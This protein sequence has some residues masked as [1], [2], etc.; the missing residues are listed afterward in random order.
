MKDHDFCP[1]YWTRERLADQNPDHVS[2]I[3]P[4]P[5]R[6]PEV[7]GVLTAKRSWSER[8]HYITDLDEELEHD[9]ASAYGFVESA[10]VPDRPVAW[11]IVVKALAAF[12]LLCAG[13]GLMFVGFGGMYALEWVR[14]LLA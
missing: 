11:I 7:E 2:G 10:S 1:V 5:R 6:Y 12:V 14:E 3:E 13:L 9:T 8:R 4:E